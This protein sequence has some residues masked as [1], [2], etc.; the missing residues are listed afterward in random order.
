[1][2]PLK[3]QNSLEVVTVNRRDTKIF[4][5]VHTHTHTHTHILVRIEVQL[6]ATETHV[7]SA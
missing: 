7:V 5:G 1:M 2:T 6:S 3:D 4:Q